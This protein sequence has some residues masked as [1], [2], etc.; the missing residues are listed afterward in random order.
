[1]VEDRGPPVHFGAS[2]FVASGTAIGLGFRPRSAPGDAL[3]RLSKTALGVA[4]Y[5]TG[6]FLFALNDA[7]GKWL[8]KDYG[9][10]QLMMLRALGAGFVLAPMAASLNANLRDFRKPTLQI[11][12]IFAMAGDTFS[13]Y[14]ATRYLPLAD[15][16]TF[17]MATPLI[18][19]ALSAPLLGER[20]EPFRWA[21][22]SVGFV[23]VAIA[24]K[25][26]PEVFSSASLLS[27]NGATMFALGQIATRKLRRT[28]WLPLVVWQFLGA[29]LIGAATTPWAWATPTPVDL[30]LMFLV[31]V[32]SMTCFIFITKALSMV[33]AAVL[34]P[35]QYSAILWA[36][37]MGWIVW[38]D[39]PGAPILVG[40]AIII[41]SGLY[42][43]FAGAR[44][45]ASDEPARHGPPDRRPA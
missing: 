13:F 2:D 22:V 9:V 11:L 4:L 19:T 20:V 16:M 39:A 37:L 5:L 43:A 28:H 15:V 31:G 35:L 8:V 23:G 41:V 12:R 36:T 7:L 34:A 21:A 42:V 45:L 25:P 6:V 33:R 24:L 32:V 40:N 3:P 38:R 26:T 10:G 18:V 29:G 1:M 17:Y 30:M 14:L 27:L 44:P